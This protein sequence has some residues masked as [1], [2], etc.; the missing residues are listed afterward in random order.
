MTREEFCKH[1]TIDNRLEKA[2]SLGKSQISGNNCGEGNEGIEEETWQTLR[3]K[4]KEEQLPAPQHWHH[5]L[6]IAPQ[7]KTEEKALTWKP[8]PK[9][10]LTEKLKDRKK[11]VT[12]KRKQKINHISDCWKGI[13]MFQM[14]PHTHTDQWWMC[15]PVCTLSTQEAEPGGLLLRL[16]W[17]TKW[18]GKGWR[19]GSAVKALVMQSWEPAVWIPGAHL[20]AG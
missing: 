14:I 12:A 8:G 13:L 7:W 19:D 20:K 3:N 18:K 5:L 10:F 16:A 17:A 6:M 11:N 9:C 4:R 1:W 2:Q 15:L